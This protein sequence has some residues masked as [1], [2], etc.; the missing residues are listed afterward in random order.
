MTT[1][2]EEFGPTSYP[3]RFTRPLSPRSVTVGETVQLIAEVDAYPP[4]K[5]TWF[6]NDKELHSAP[7]VQIKSKDF[8]TTVTIVEI[9]EEE[10]G[11]YSV[12]ASNK[13]GYA[14]SMAR[15]D[16]RRK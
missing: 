7:K 1:E 3:P 12:V 13:T 9:V 11:E 4:P 2:E 16:V 14:S 15:V 6:R 5:F 8:T 10:S